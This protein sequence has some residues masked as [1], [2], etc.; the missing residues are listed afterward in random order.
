[1][2]SFKA[3][4]NL[5]K[6]SRLN[7]SPLTKGAKPQPVMISCNCSLLS[8]PAQREERPL[9]CVFLR[10]EKAAR[11]IEKR[12]SLSSCGKSLLLLRSVIT[13]DVTFGRG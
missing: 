8:F 5:M 13:V 3:L 6:S 2:E 7:V 1:M 11:V 10:W 4:D 12:K 9:T